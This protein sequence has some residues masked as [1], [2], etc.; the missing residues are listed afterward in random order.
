MLYQMHLTGAEFELT[1]LVVIGTD[2]IGGK[3][4]NCHTITTTTAL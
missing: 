4:S 3:K 1:T 2:S